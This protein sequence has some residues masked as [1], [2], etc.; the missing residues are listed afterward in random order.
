MAYSPKFTIT[1]KILMN[2][3]SIEGAKAIIES[4]PLIPSWER[5]FQKE[6]VARTI[7]YSTH[8]EGNPLNFTEVKKII[9][10]QEEDV[11]ARERDIKE[12]INYRKVMEYIDEIAKT[13][14]EEGKS[15]YI[16]VD[17]IKGVHKILAEKFLAMDRGGKYREH[18]ATS[19]NSI[20]KEITI[21]YP[22]ADE[23]AAGVEN[24]L[25]WLNS[26]EAQ[27]NHPTLKS[28]IIHHELVR[29]HPFDDLNGRT[30]RV[31]STLSLYLDGY[32][33]KNFFSLEEHF[34]SDAQNYYDALKSIADKEPDLTTWL[35]YFTEGLA[36]ELHRVK[37]KVLKLS[38]DAKLKAA[39]G[40][41]VY[42]SE[43]QETIVEHIQNYGSVSNKDFEK[44]F[45]NVSDDTVLR[46]L[47][48]LKKKGA[49]K[50]EGST[51]S[52]RYVLG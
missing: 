28:G 35:E 8:I 48:D 13:E 12:I 2:I 31:T 15:Y 29:I 40:G 50:K 47:T 16:G 21:V 18:G 9:S 7:H 52:A 33:I 1:N 36:I 51:K 24:F 25:S 37:D 6:A 45:P 26:E 11:V 32:D 43:R 39:V 46:E 20:T 22:P 34:D 42:L 17:L 49:I 41:Q 14:K 10:G 23:I 30:A 38:K 5:Q 27:N 4:S 19:R 44:M 3:G